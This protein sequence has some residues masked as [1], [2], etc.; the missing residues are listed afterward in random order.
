M[1]TQIIEM[2][3]ASNRRMKKIMGGEFKQEEIQ[4][5]QREFEGQIKLV[6]AVVQA[7]AVSSKNRRT[8]SSLEKMNLMDNNDAIEIGLSQELDKVKCPDVN[9]IITRA[10]CLDYSGQEEHLGTCTT[11]EQFPI[12][13]GR[14]LPEG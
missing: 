4:A 8:M 1:S 10:E 14:L 7:F 13:R 12:T 5:A 9:K 11:C 3:E 2:F 6:N